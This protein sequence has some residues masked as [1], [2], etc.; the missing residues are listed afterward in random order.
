MP[1]C[2]LVLS[3]FIVLTAL[4]SRSKLK[5]KNV[6]INPTRNGIL[7]I[8]KLMG[9]KIKLRNITIYKSEKIADIEI[10]SSKNLKAINC[11]QKLNSSAIDE[12]LVIFLVAAKAKGISYFKNLSYH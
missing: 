12:F 2:L 10:K 8:L 11:P 9:V 4:S 1:V 6:N 3:F 7:K 5:I